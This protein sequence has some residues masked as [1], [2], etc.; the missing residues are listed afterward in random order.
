MPDRIILCGYER[1]E[2][3]RVVLNALERLPE[4]LP[5][6]GLCE[7]QA[8]PW[9]DLEEEAATPPL[10]RQRPLP[11]CSLDEVPDQS[12]T[13]LIV[14][15]GAIDALLARWQHV[16]L[17]VPDAA[18]SVQHPRVFVLSSTLVDV[19]VSILRPLLRS[20][21][22]R[23]TL[24]A[25][26]PL[27]LLGE[28]AVQA[29]LREVVSL[30]NGRGALLDFF[31]WQSVFNSVPVQPEETRQSCLALEERLDCSAVQVSLIRQQTTLLY[32]LTLVMDVQF[33]QPLTL[34]MLQQLLSGLPIHWCTQAHELAVVEYLATQ[35]NE[36]PRLGLY[37]EHQGSRNQTLRVVVDELRYGLG[38]QL[39]RI[40]SVIGTAL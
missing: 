38:M 4:D 12:G 19:S 5:V 28:Q 9:A 27:S 8:E 15:S 16:R 26:E 30:L 33:A 29:A 7:Q 10:F 35:E 24:M 36:L 23:V 1:T 18:C 20:G 39:L 21:L 32:G 11:L 25:L 40:L 6:Q 34:E 3:C 37:V 17:V 13:V 2:R 22:Q 31:P 14:L